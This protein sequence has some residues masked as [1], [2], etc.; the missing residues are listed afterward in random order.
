MP[1][2]SVQREEAAVA[3]YSEG[4][5]ESV[6][7]APAL[8]NHGLPPVARKWAGQTPV[9]LPIPPPI[10]A[11][12]PGGALTVTDQQLSKVLRDKG[13]PEHLIRAGRTGLIRQWVAF[14]KEVQEGYELGFYDYANDLDLRTLLAE[15]ALD[16]DPQVM[17]ADERLR[18]LLRPT[19]KPIWHGP[20]N[21]YWVGGYPRNAGNKLMDDLRAR[22]LIPGGTGP[23]A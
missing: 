3:R 19:E 17:Q 10:R 1:L 12:S 13:C 5:A 18:K 4:D 14:V 23:Q 22:G 8:I 20:E 21:A 16:S 11:A 9:A 7:V 2:I 15:T 6:L